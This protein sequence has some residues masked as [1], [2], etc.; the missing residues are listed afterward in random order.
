[1]QVILKQN[2]K[3]VLYT[4]KKE[5]NRYTLLK[6]EELENISKLSQKTS[7]AIWEDV[8]DIV[9][10]ET[11]KLK[12]KKMVENLIKKNIINQIGDI[13][14]L[15]ITYK[16]VNQ[17]GQ[18][19]VFNVFTLPEKQ[20][21]ELNIPPK[22]HSKIDKFT[23]IPFAL[24]YY[25]NLLKEKNVLH[26]YVKDN[27]FMAVYTVNKTL[28]FVRITDFPE[29]TKELSLIENIV[30]TY[31]YVNTNIT[32]PDVVI[33]SGEREIFNK[34]SEDV[35]KSLNRP[36]CELNY[37]YFFKDNPED[38]I[39]PV[40]ILN[41]ED[42]YNFLPERIKKE[43]SVY[44]L[45]KFTSIILILFNILIFFKV[46]T[47]STKVLDNYLL[48][49]DLQLKNQQL[50]K[51]LEIMLK[52]KDIEFLVKRYNLLQEKNNQIKSLNEILKIEKDI[53]KPYDSF[54]YTFNQN[55]SSITLSY[56]KEFKTYKEMERY[57]E[58][59][60]DAN[61]VVEKDYKNKTVKVKVNYGN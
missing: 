39:V 8:I 17:E 60:K 41:L 11:P 15:H 51:T 14:G 49:E 24:I 44:T 2:D 46:I 53:E 5:K 30:L 25:N 33:L 52:G 37:E 58:S 18:S 23:V 43:N 56:V 45:Y 26:F 10:V 20:F 48:M 13:R 32:V 47:L 54:R 31:R 35:Y 40:G 27:I 1:M 9:K 34:I 28:D 29:D 36:L 22:Y 59:I 38:L 16:P 12:N 55:K 57:V 19:V 7:I 4:V 50:E 42:P 6:K 3:T 61:K 21:Y